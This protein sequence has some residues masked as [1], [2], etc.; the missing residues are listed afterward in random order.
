MFSFL[1]WDVGATEIFIKHSFSFGVACLNP[2]YIFYIYKYI[3]IYDDLYFKQLYE[4]NGERASALPCSLW[5]PHASSGDPGGAGGG[6]RVSRPGGCS[7]MFLPTPAPHPPALGL[8][9]SS[10]CKISWSRARTEV[11]KHKPS[12]KTLRSSGTHTHIH[13]DAAAWLRRR[14]C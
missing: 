11:L 8:W 10:P 5:P 2:L 6:S 3:Y 14:A 7:L 13:A 1:L 9:P 12:W 4:I